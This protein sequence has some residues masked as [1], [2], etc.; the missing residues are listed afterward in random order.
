MR[1][2]R[3]RKSDGS[4]NGTLGWRRFAEQLDQTIDVG[5][6]IFGRVA[7]DSSRHKKIVNETRLV[8]EPFD[9]LVEP[10]PIAPRRQRPGRGRTERVYLKRRRRRVVSYCLTLP[11]LDKT[12]LIEAPT[13]VR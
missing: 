12:L 8:R 1:R 4:V 10:L 9:G 11:E 5:A 13:H 6:A 7:S 3:F 2:S